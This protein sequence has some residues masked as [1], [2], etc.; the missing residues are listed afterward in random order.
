MVTLRGGN[1]RAGTRCSQRA[2]IAFRTI[3]TDGQRRAKMLAGGNRHRSLPLFVGVPKAR[4]RASRQ[5]ASGQRPYEAVRTRVPDPSR[6]QAAVLRP[7]KRGKRKFF[8]QGPSE[9]MPELPVQSWPDR[10]ER[11]ISRLVA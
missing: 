9:G 1:S 3:Q 7:H 11:E 2:I 6:G 8:K 10:S 5:G 4:Y